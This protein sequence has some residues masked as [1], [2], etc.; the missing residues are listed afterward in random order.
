MK[1]YI[2]TIIIAIAILASGFIV[3]KAY[4]YKFK[5]RN[6][7]SVVGSAEHNF[8]ADLIVWSGAF[9]R[10]SMDM[11]EAYASLKN[12][13]QQ[14]RSY[15][16]SRGIEDKEVIFSSIAIDRQFN[17]TYDENGRQTGNV[18]TGYQL[19]QTMK[20]ESKSM[21]KVEKIS[22]EITELLQ[23]GIELSSQPPL[24]YYTKLS[25]LKIDLL[26][27]ASADAHER[28]A[29]TAKNAHSSLGK[30]RRASMGVFQITGQYSNEDYSYGGS[31]N[32]SSKNKTASI[33]V[34]LEYE[35]E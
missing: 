31:F 18:F 6:T 32:T 14:V 26:A 7:V 34:R 10:T 20:I 28:A 19:R 3:G 11:K 35:L 33:T 13:E 15:L 30:L 12:D 1:N 16:S 9:T 4:N 24:Y 17:T 2:S 25:N 8:V 29:T 22:R 23:S 21:E 5:T 27:K